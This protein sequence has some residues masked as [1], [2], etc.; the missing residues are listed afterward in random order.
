VV[1]AYSNPDEEDGVL[2][3]DHQAGRYLSHPEPE[4]GVDPD[5][6]YESYREDF[7]SDG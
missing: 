4:E 7:H 1:W 2:V 5:T 3:W 6:F